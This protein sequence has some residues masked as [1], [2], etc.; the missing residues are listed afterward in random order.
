MNIPTFSLPA[1]TTCSN[2]TNLCR[3]F[4]YA[5]KA[6]RMYP[7]T[8]PSRQKNFKESKEWKFIG[9]V[10]KYII[11]HN[12]KYLRIHE[13]GDFY[14]QQYLDKWCY[15]A[16]LCRDT[17]FLAYTQMYNLDTVT[18]KPDNLIIYWSVWP[19][20]I[21]V[22]DKGLFAYVID[23]GKN[24][25]SNKLDKKSIKECPKE[26]IKGMTCDKCLW[27]FDGKGN[28]KFKLH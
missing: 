23:N 14:S 20:S 18:L 10:V 3:K 26:N 8:L 2:S 5:K 1:E 15:I 6:E 16:T 9:D 21:N 24:K 28:I 13:S 12:I 22:P 19:D 11:K 25:I 17:K 27:C 7:A 4:C